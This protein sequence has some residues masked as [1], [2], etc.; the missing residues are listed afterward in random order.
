MD[1][2]EAALHRCANDLNIL[3]DRD[4]SYACAQGDNIVVVATVYLVPE[5]REACDWLRGALSTALHDTFV[6]YTNRNIVVHAA[7]PC[8]RFD[9]CTC[10]EW[11]AKQA[12]GIM[13]YATM[14]AR[15]YLKSGLQRIIQ[16][17]PWKNKKWMQS[18]LPVVHL[19]GVESMGCG[20]EA[21]DTFDKVLPRVEMDEVTR[22]TVDADIVRFLGTPPRS[23]L[24]RY[25]AVFEMVR[26]RAATS[27]HT[28][29]VYESL[30]S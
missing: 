7:Q 14:C 23:L 10:T 13:D 17:Y 1:Q 2:L 19:Q 12:Q 25:E 16:S 21:R 20:I 6:G 18:M 5:S 22:N 4:L 26:T 24:E 30:F 3:L 27:P 8:P 29:R 11:N 28:L 15:V 9:A